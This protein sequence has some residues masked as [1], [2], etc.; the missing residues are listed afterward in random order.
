VIDLISAVGVAFAVVFVAELGDKTQ[1]LALGFGARHRLGLVALGLTLGYAAANLVATVVGAVIG[2]A[3]PERPI[4]IAAGVLFLVFAVLALRGH[5]PN[6]E[7]GA[8]RL[9]THGIVAAIAVSIAIAEIGDK[10]QL[11]TAALAARNQP[12]GTWIGATAGA[13]SAGLVGA[14]AGQRIGARLSERVLRI[15]SAV[16]FGAFGVLLIITA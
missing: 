2:A 1:L 5:D 10:T 11:A 8:P 12:V 9:A 15:A 3:L 14:F 6:D 7:D 13:A 16:L 4:G